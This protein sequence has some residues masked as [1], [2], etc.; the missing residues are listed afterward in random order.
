MPAGRSAVALKPYT[1]PEPAF[2]PGSVEHTQRAAVA[3][4]LA[5]EDVRLVAG[6]TVPGTS[7]EEGTTV[8]R[9]I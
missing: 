2:G 7:C 8:S 4:D 6:H 9:Q 1:P 3:L 5:A